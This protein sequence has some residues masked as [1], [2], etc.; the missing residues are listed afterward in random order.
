MESNWI[1]CNKSLP[2]NKSF[3]L[4]YCWPGE[5]D[6]ALFENGKFTIDYDQFGYATPTHWMPLPN[7]PQP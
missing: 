2:E 7:Q 1:E 4:I 6:V 5:M 3:V